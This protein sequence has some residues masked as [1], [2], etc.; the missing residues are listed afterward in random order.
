VPGLLGGGSL[1]DRW[2]RRPLLLAG[3]T[4]AGLGNLALLCW[5]DEAGIFVGR[6]VV[7]VGVG[8]AMSAG[9]AWSADLGGK[10]GSVLAGIALSAG[11]GCG[12]VASGLLAEFVP[13]AT[14]VPFVVTAVLSAGAV[15]VAAVVARVS[16]RP[17]TQGEQ[18]L[19]DTPTGAVAALT[20][21]LPMALWVFSCATVAMVTMSERLQY[22]YRGPWLPGVAAAVTLSSGVVIQM[23]ARSRGWGP[24]AGIAGALCAAVGFAIV[25]AAGA[26][27]SLAVFVLSAVVLGLAYGLCLQKGLVDIETLSPPATR[28]T[29]TGVFYAVTYLGFGLP[30][31]LVALE[32]TVGIT[33]PL[34]V[35]SVAAAATAVLRA[36]QTRVSARTSTRA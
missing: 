24:R 13:A 36:A 14:V 27:P 33:A 5:H 16:A 32:P 19:P 4:V 11:F 26:R 28:G 12:P 6:L 20:A 25:A 30:V 10:S 34:V 18:Q 2:G 9:T 23:I 1:S 29:L 7:G 17:E 8:V 21:A 31:L 22:H 3:A 35:L 15:A